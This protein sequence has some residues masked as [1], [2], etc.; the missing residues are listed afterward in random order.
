MLVVAFSVHERDGYDEHAGTA[1]H[2]LH[3]ELLQHD[4]PQPLQVDLVLLIAE[5]VVTFGEQRVLHL[6]IC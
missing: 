4:V 6:S 5:G 2:V 3:E 1:P